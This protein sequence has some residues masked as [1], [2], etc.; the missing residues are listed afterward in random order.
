MDRF[1]VNK[2]IDFR[3]YREHTIQK[4][5]V[6]IKNLSK[7]GRDIKTTMIVDNVEANFKLNPNNGY[8]IK[9]FEGEEEDEELLYLQKELIALIEFNPEDIRDYIPILRNNML[10]R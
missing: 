3:L 9:N 7:I 4:D 10:N 6:N 1:D 5:G 2:K 8:H